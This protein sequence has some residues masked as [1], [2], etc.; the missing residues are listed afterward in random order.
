MWQLVQ[1]ARQANFIPLKFGIRDHFLNHPFDLADELI[2][3]E[4]SYLKSIFDPV[5]RKLKELYCNDSLRKTCK[6]PN[7]YISRRPNINLNFDISRQ[8]TINLNFEKPLNC[9][10]CLDDL[11]LAAK[12]HF[13]HQFYLKE[14]FDTKMFYKTY[15]KRFH[16]KVEN[17]QFPIKSIFEASL[18]NLAREEN[19]H[20]LIESI[21]E[22][23]ENEARVENDQFLL[24]AIIEPKTI[25]NGIF[26]EDIL[27]L[28]EPALENF[29]MEQ[30]VGETN[31]FETDIDASDSNGHLHDHWISFSIIQ[32]ILQCLNNST[33]VKLLIRML[34]YI[35][36]SKT[37]LTSAI[38]LTSLIIT[39]LIP[40]SAAEET[41]LSNPNPT[42]TDKF[43]KF[44][45]LTML[46]ITI[47]DITK[48]TIAR[49]WNSNETNNKK[50]ISKLNS[51]NTHFRPTKLHLILIFTCFNSTT[52]SSLTSMN[53]GIL[54]Y[55]RGET[56]LNPTTI[57]S[58][59]SYRPCDALI[60]DDLLS[61]N[62]KFHKEACKVKIM[63]DFDSAFVKNWTNNFILLKEKLPLP[64]ARRTCRDLGSSLVTVKNEN[65]ARLLYNFM[66]YH[67]I[68]RTFAGI[69]NNNDILEP[70]F[71]DDSSLAANIYFPTIFDNNNNKN[72]SWNEVLEKLDNPN[73]YYHRHS[74]YEFRRHANL[75]LGV[76]WESNNDQQ[77][78]QFGLSRNLWTIC[79]R[80][81]SSTEAQMAIS[82]WINDCSRRQEYLKKTSELIH[83][84]VQEILPSNIPP[85]NPKKLDNTIYFTKSMYGMNPS[86]SDNH[87]LRHENNNNFKQI[88]QQDKIPLTQQCNQLLMTYKANISTQIVRDER[89]F[90]MAALSVAF[91][92]FA[93]AL[94]KTLQSTTMF[95]GYDNNQKVSD[96][97][98][99]WMIENSNFDRE[100]DNAI[101]FTSAT[102]NEQKIY[103]TSEKIISY[104]N[105]LH[106]H[107]TK[108]AFS[109]KYIAKANDYFSNGDYDLFAQE[110]KTKYGVS[111]PNNKKDLKTQVIVSDNSYMIVF[112]IPIN[113]K[114]YHHDLYELIP[115][116][117]FNNAQK[118]YPSLGAKYIAVSTT[119]TQTYN[120]LDYDEMTRCDAEPFCVVK[121]PSHAAY[122]PTCGICSF[123]GR[124]ECCEFNEAQDIRP[125]FKTI[126][127]ATFYSV[128]DQQPITL[129][130]SCFSTKTRG[131]GSK[132]TIEIKGSGYFGLELGCEATWQDI[133][134]RSAETEFFE[135]IE[136]NKNVFTNYPDSNQK[137]L[138]NDIRFDIKT[139]T[140]DKLAG[141]YLIPI[142]IIVGILA[143]FMFLIFPATYLL[144]KYYAGN[145][146][147]RCLTK[148][149]SRELAKLDRHIIK[150]PEREQNKTRISRQGSQEVAI[151]MICPP[152]TPPMPISQSK[153]I[154][155]DKN[156]RE[157]A[158]SSKKQKQTSLLEGNSTNLTREQIFQALNSLD[159]KE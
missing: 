14:N 159:Q 153:S 139:L 41:S 10:W 79:L 158:K 126:E 3:Q 73:P 67:N 89:G 134:I 40:G 31:D 29:E 110:V 117:R 98:I 100:L 137:G 76:W 141:K 80:P 36:A 81:K 64:M 93:F 92:L 66:S 15:S 49:I 152:T 72:S 129:D 38:L 84:K 136:S 22:T 61:K 19:D 97:V 53:N 124:S 75:D 131:V 111:I 27:D 47:F 145:N 42:T 147:L 45:I 85:S 32:F 120:I 138:L 105:G 52:A 55:H 35:G 82:T 34:C 37:C 156:R 56:F 70:T 11:T 65:D 112:I 118:F 128:N 21:I 63:N 154:K 149:P 68:H 96:P 39:G 6:H 2:R 5:C 58:I 18:R 33:I 50:P 71:D 157:K 133:I 121:N 94:E 102:S 86:N 83:R 148:Y 115:L 113:A 7:K 28:P 142:L 17:E 78:K 101:K 119:G 26:S 24:E 114:K 150:G 74:Y 25:V 123:Y 95:A 43:P 99:P 48:L 62:V 88:L 12:R 135:P 116:G 16:P 8:P 155:S 44:F 108:I 125:D 109:H 60:F 20:L 13:D 106:E 104:I 127:N 54:F 132:N 130:V 51:S 23:V 4:K 90:A 77:W 143:A 46:A 1:Q 9:F 103:S 30:E 91:S 59:K 140:S 69:T 144:L 122:T 87:D 57:K 151:E 107:L 146:I